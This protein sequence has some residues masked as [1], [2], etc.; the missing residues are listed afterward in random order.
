MIFDKTLAKTDDKP[1]AGNSRVTL[2]REPIGKRA[3]LAAADADTALI[4]NP[5]PLPVSKADCVNCEAVAAGADAKPNGLPND[6]AGEPKAG[7]VDAAVLD[8]GDV[9]AAAAPKLKPA[10]AGAGAGADVADGC[11]DCSVWDEE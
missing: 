8:D 6:G 2:T 9:N 10:V 3:A 11:V 5:P 7:V 4:A 1:A